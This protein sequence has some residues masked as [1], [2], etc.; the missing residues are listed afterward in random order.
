MRGRL[1]SENILL[2]E[3]LLRALDQKNTPHK[4]CII[5]YLSKVFDSVSWSA[6]M[7]VIEALRFSR[8]VR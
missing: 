8:P 7:R 6:L 3:E 2:L 4:A 1:I 5:F